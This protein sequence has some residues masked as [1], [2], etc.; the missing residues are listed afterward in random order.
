MMEKRKAER[1]KRVEIMKINNEEDGFDD[2]PDEEELEVE[3][4]ELEDEEYDN[5]EEDEDEESE[6]EE[7]DVEMKDKRRIK[8]AFED[9]EAL[10]EDEM[11]EN[12]DREDDNDSIALEDIPKKSQFKKIVDPDLLSESSNTSDIF[13][14]LDRIRSDAETPTLNQSKLNLTSAPSSN[15][16]FG[17]IISAEPRW[18]PFQDRITAGT[19]ELNSAENTLQE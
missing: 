11:S 14:K 5:E 10:D 1:I 13:N 9:D 7:N 18:T 2:L 16:S 8:R 19:V 12:D 15:S 3:D 6:L 4:E 17:A